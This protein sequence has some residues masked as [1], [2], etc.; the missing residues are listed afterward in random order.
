[1]I[2]GY[3]KQLTRR[4]LLFVLQF[5]CKCARASG[6]ARSAYVRTNPGNIPVLESSFEAEAEPFDHLCLAL[7]SIGLETCN[8]LYVTID[9][10][11]ISSTRLLIT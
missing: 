4:V 6:L 11:A 8:Y 1:M 10:A 2:T 9:F 5:Y 3:Y 7:I